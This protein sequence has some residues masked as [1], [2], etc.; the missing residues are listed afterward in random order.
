M[1]LRL[2]IS[3]LCA[4]LTA[5]ISSASIIGSTNAGDF[6]DTVNWC[7]FGCIDAQYAT[8]QAWVSTQGAT[9]V[10]RLVDTQQGMFNLMQSVTWFGNFSNNMGLVYNG[11][12]FENTP[13]DIAATFDQGVYG[14]GAYIQANYFGAFQAT[15]TLFDIN[16]QPLGAFT[17]NGVS[18]PIP[19]TALFIGGYIG[20][21]DVWAVQFDAAGTS[22]YEPDF[23]IGTMGLRTTVPE[24]SS[25]LLIAPAV[26]ALSAF[27]RRRRHADRDR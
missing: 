5:G 21:P 2:S 3:I 4:L 8:P 7:Q 27:A 14:A 24:P 16:Y 18:E 19:G 9:G 17:T 25:L 20:T 22:S 23:A 1:R 13:T 12:S 10:I 6:Q 26:L 11:A 15:V